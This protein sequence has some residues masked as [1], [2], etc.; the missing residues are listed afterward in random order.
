[1]NASNDTDRRMNAVTTPPRKKRPQAKPQSL[2]QT[3]ETL[4]LANRAM[5]TRDWQKAVDL[6]AEL[7]KRGA[8]SA[9]AYDQAARALMHLDRS[10]EAESLIQDGMKQ[11]P[12]N[13]TL[14][15]RQ[16]T[17]ASHRKDWSQAVT[18]WQAFHARFKG[19]AY[20]HLQQGRVLIQAGQIDEAESLLQRATERWPADPLLATERAGLATHRRDWPEAL[21]RWRALQARFGKSASAC[22][23]ECEALI[24]LGLTDEAEE[25]L[26][27]TMADHPDHP[28][29]MMQGASLA[30]QR[31]DWPTACERW[32]AFRRRFGVRMETC[33]QEVDAL[34]RA[35]Q[36]SEAEQ[37]LLE[38]TR[39]FP[40]RRPLALKLAQLLSQHQNWAA[41]AERWKILRKRF[42]P[43]VECFQE[44]AQ[45]L[46]RLD[47]L[48]EA[49]S[50]LAQAVRRWPRDK[51]LVQQWAELATLR[52]DWPSATQRW[53][54]LRKMYPNHCPA[55]LRGI[56]VFMRQPD[57]DQADSLLQE[58]L[59]RFPGNARLMA[60]Q[61]GIHQA[62]E[63][64]DNL[65]EWENFYRKVVDGDLKPA[66]ASTAPSPAP[67]EKTAGFWHKLLQVVR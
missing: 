57:P 65:T 53:Q 3:D 30:V 11:F 55:Y 46:T 60:L 42:P 22:Q 41:A 17:L 19:T 50:L 56:E 59:N 13:A 9:L 63:E 64:A 2:K 10:E 58:A 27:A 35:G 25:C 14:V 48:D 62:R 54:K 40:N 52:E 32:A 18:R 43:T 37:L 47:R 34:T 7:R 33:E 23:G 6:W 38:A 28:G 1:M 21:E 16:A 15:M 31:E 36:R 12:A 51:K 24:A 20:S 45:A 66:A 8:R 61:A 44:E 4:K 29:L 49:E 39:R 67:A 5:K 26:K